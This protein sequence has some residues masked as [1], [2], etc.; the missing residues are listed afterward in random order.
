MPQGQSFFSRQYMLDQAFEAF[1]YTSTDMKQVALHLHDYYEI[2]LF[3]CGDVTYTID[4]T[5]YNLMPGD[6]LLIAPQT[7]H[8]PI[9]NRPDSLYSRLVLWIS[10]AFMKSASETCALNFLMPFDIISEHK[11]HLLRLSPEA[12]KPLFDLAYQMATIESGTYAR[13]MNNI[14]LLDFLVRLNEQYSQYNSQG[15]TQISYSPLFVHIVDYI[16]NNLTQPLTLDSIALRFYISKFYLAHAFKARM[17]LSVHQYINR[18][19]IYQSRQLLQSGVLANR[20]CH[21]CGFSNYSAFYK[22]FKAVYG[23]SPRHMMHYAPQHN[24]VTV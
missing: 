6:I 7:P 10:P 24:P 5:R 23:V 11:H 17:G 3:E 18:R 13:A 8:Q 1:Y 12:R 9:F 22:A 19:R 20:A 14:S 15:D 4:D 2:Y 16:N 21:L